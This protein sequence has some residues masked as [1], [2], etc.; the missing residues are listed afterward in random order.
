MSEDPGRSLSAIFG[1]T[2]ANLHWSRPVKALAR[3]SVR[4]ERILV[5]D[6]ERRRLLLLAKI[7]VANRQGLDP[8]AYKT[9]NG[10]SGEAPRQSHKST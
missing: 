4:L 10:V 9:P 3:A 1:S 6:R 5:I 2:D 8:G 7:A